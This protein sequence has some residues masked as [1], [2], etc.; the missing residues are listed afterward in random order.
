MKK[1][2]EVFVYENTK[3]D[4]SDMSKMPETARYMALIAK[5]AKQAASNLSK[6]LQ[7]DIESEEQKVE[8]LA[9]N[10]SNAHGWFCREFA[11]RRGLHWLGTTTTWFL[12]H[13]AFYSHNLFQKDIL[14]R[15]YYSR[16]L[17]YSGFY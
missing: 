4:A 7:T 5:N 14:Q 6:V 9:Q 8:Q 10:R 16:L 12:L 13:I 17:V 11:H 2:T 3:L 15:H 1:F